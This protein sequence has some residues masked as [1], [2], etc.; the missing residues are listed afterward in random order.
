MQALGSPAGLPPPL[1]TA[2]RCP[3]P[4][5]G[6]EASVLSGASPGKAL[7]FRPRGAPSPAYRPSPP[8]P[9]GESLEAGVLASAGHPP[10]ARPFQARGPH[11]LASPVFPPPSRLTPLLPAQSRVSGPQSPGRH[12]PHCSDQNPG[13]TGDSPPSDPSQRQVSS[14]QLPE[15]V[16]VH[17]GPRP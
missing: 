3:E 12:L 8:P 10:G 14:A 16:P 6:R 5:A 13:E 15:H 7:R 17:V 11:T 2:S 4:R 1:V 9:A